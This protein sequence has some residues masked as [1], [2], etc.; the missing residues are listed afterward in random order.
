MLWFVTILSL[1]FIFGFLDMLSSP[2]FWGIVVPLF[3]IIQIAKEKQDERQQELV[4]S[5]TFQR[6]RQE[7]L[8]KEKNIERQRLEKLELNETLRLAREKRE[9]IDK[10]ATEIIQ[11]EVDWFGSKFYLLDTEGKNT[12]VSIV[13]L[14]SVLRKILGLVEDWQLESILFISD[15]NEILQFKNM[16][17]FS[18][19]EAILA[20]LS[21]RLVSQNITG[22]HL[23]RYV[24]TVSGEKIPLS[25]YDATYSAIQLFEI[26]TNDQLYRI[27]IP[28]KEYTIDISSN[29]NNNTLIEYFT[30]LL[31]CA[32]YHDEEIKNGKNKEEKILLTENQ[33]SECLG[34][35]FLILDDTVDKGKIYSVDQIRQLLV[36]GGHTW[37]LNQVTRRLVNLYRTG[38]ITRFVVGRVT[39]CTGCEIIDGKTVVEEKVVGECECGLPVSYQFK[40]ND[41]SINTKITSEFKTKIVAIS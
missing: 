21:D 11:R 3:I 23:T 13:V 17:N 32:K 27:P 33:K 36:E 34:L 41:D 18:A 30:T 19:L 7:R 40:V 38:G 12:E 14:L 1:Y 4:Q 20:M 2:W 37:T 35:A 6:E 24:T 22:P 5:R 8:E 16:D 9:N 15:D 39:V 31:A 26:A 28:C 10:T 25:F 29:Y